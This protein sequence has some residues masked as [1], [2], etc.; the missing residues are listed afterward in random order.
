M[1]LEGYQQYDERVLGSNEY[2]HSS[3][4][5][6][7]IGLQANGEGRETP[8]WDYKH[9]SAFAAFVR[10]IPGTYLGARGHGLLTMTLQRCK[11]PQRLRS[12]QLDLA[13]ATLSKHEPSKK[14]ARASLTFP[15]LDPSLPLVIV[16]VCRVARLENQP[17][18]SVSW[19]QRQDPIIAAA[20][21]YGLFYL[22]F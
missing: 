15:H 17:L 4:A 16:V 18:C 22:L 9:C 3:L 11:S 13:T 2:T 7:T 1:G 21:K 20:P 14:G 10:E 5:L 19:D 8:R 12:L 6:V